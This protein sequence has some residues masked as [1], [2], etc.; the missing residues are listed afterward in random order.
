MPV[1]DWL[2]KAC[3]MLSS[4]W[5]TQGAP[6][7]DEVATE[8][9]LK[10][11]SQE[12]AGKTDQNPEWT[13]SL[14]PPVGVVNVDEEGF[15]CRVGERARKRRREAR[16]TA[17]VKQKPS[18]AKGEGEYFPAVVTTKHLSHAESHCIW[19]SIFFVLAILTY[20]LAIRE[21]KA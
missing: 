4:V 17:T 18:D 5:R 21:S 2:E 16:K 8:D 10:R 6:E 12:F 7:S 15:D 11:L 1:Q 3:N 14:A 20:T 13:G 9:F 19:K